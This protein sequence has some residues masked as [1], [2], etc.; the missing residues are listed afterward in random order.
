MKPEITLTLEKKI[1]KKTKNIF[2]NINIYSSV[3]QTLISMMINSGSNLLL[4]FSQKNLA[5]KLSTFALRKQH[6]LIL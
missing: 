2:K 3:L 1:N 5:S 6:K 4:Y